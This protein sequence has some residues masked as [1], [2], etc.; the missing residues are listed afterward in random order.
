MKKLSFVVMLAIVLV[1]LVSCFG[2]NTADKKAPVFENA[3]DN[4]LPE[5][6]ILVKTKTSEED[7]IADVTAT[8]E[9]D[10]KVVVVVT[11]GNFDYTVV[12]KYT[13]TYTAVDAAGNVATATRIVN[14]I[15]TISPYFEYANS[16]N[17]KLP[18]HEML[19]YTD[20]DLLELEYLTVIDNYDK[21]LVATV[22]DNGGFNKDVA[23]T[24]TV[25][26]SVKDSSGNETTAQRDIMVNPAV[27]YIEDVLRINGESHPAKYNDENALKDNGSGLALRSENTV[28]VMSG[29]FYNAQIEANVASYAKN[30]GSPFLPYGVAVIV[31]ANFKP[32]LVRNAAY[33]IE[34]IYDAENS[35]WKV[36]KGQDLTFIDSTTPS[37]SAVGILGGDFQSYIPEGGYV[38]LAG[39]ALGGNLDTNKIFLI[40]NLLA[41][42]FGGG[43]LGWDAVEGVANE[44]LAAAQ[45]EFV[46]DYTTYY[47]QPAAIE[48]PVLTMANHVLSWTKATG[49][50]AYELYINGEL[51]LTTTATSVKMIDLGLEPSAEGEHYEITVKALTEDVRYYGDSALSEVLEYAMPNSTELSAPVVELNE[52]ILTWEAIEGAVKY[53]I[54]AKQLGDAVLLG[55]S[56]ECSFDLTQNEEVKKLIANANIYVKAI[57]D[58]VEYL[59]SGLSEAVV[60]FCSVEKVIVINGEKQPIIETTA[61]DYFARRNDT[62]EVGYVSKSYLYLITDAQNIVSTYNEAYS[63]LVLFDKTGAVKAMI[64]ILA[65]TQQYHNYEWKTPAE[66]G[67]TANSAQIAPL[68]N[69]ISEGDQLLIGRTGGTFTINGSMVRNNGRDVVANYFWG[70]F[71]EGGSDPW[72]AEHTITEYPTF[73]IKLANSSQL[74]SP[75]VTANGSVVSWEAVD[76]AQSYEVY[77]N[78]TLAAT[79]TETSYDVVSYLG[80]IGKTAEKGVNYTDVK[81]KVIAKAEGKEDSEPAIKNYRFSA[82]LTD[83]TNNLNVNVNVTS[84]FYNAG[85]GASCRL[86]DNVSSLLTGAKY[87]EAVDTYVK[88]KSAYA[89]NAYHAFMQNGI[90]VIL[91]KDLNVK[92]IRFGYVNASQIDGE[93]NITAP[94]TWNNNTVNATNGGG[95]FLNIENEVEDTDYVVIITNAGSKAQLKAACALFINSDVEAVITQKTSITADSLVET[96]VDLANAEYQIVYTVAEVA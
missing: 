83:G 8:D 96:R 43:A 6:N 21:D 18:A 71:V 29:E 32:V 92:Q 94:T 78:D 54:Y 35:A 59:D 28:F 75:V 57:G 51:V 68:L 5:K 1:S 34:A 42:S 39:S 14:V 80:T 55:E 53:E 19:Q 89:N 76:G 62:S 7:L 22:A 25:T 40:K 17:N 63:F 48:A 87:K 74:E 66:I 4:V 30:G 61:D 91:D 36:Q 70:Q 15:D 49:A 24:Y 85:S 77:V 93:Y 64:N 20:C 31:D 26:Y 23:G 47:P 67:Y 72:R 46:E 84:V 27:K 73:K 38:L 95:N 11:L 58:N 56:T 9:V 37:A 50:K 12:G 2:E 86:T 90:I 88:D 13:L 65:T 10:G 3:I 60:Y 69:I 33:A 82:Q 79:I 16:Q 44:L 41:S 81:V 52:G 45:F